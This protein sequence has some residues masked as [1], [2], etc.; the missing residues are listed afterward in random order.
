MKDL[1]TCYKNGLERM[2]VIYKQYIIKIEPQN[3]QGRR[4]LEIRRT[5]HKDYA[6]KK[7]TERKAR[8]R[9]KHD[10]EVSS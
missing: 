5:R 8:R 2:Q 4:A 6:E 10:K 3:A 1:V 9:Q 7:R